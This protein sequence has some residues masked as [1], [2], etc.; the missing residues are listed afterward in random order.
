MRAD[1]TVEAEVMNV[2]EDFA[3]AYVKNDED[4]LLKLIDPDIVLI[5]TEKEDRREGTEEVVTQMEDDW[6]KYTYVS[7]EFGWRAVSMHESMAWVATERTTRK[8][9]NEKDTIVSSRLTAV[10]KKEDNKWRIMQWH[11]SVPI[12]T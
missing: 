5:G 9:I 7:I 12:L 2:L 3:E 6:K 10:L 11:N 8:T 1:K 4:A